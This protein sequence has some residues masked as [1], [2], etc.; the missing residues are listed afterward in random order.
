MPRRAQPA[1]AVAETTVDPAARPRPPGDTRARPHRVAGRDTDPR[2]GRRP[3]G[4]GGCR[5]GPRGARELE[6]KAATLV[7]EQTR[8]DELTQDLN[9]GRLEL[10]SAREEH[11]Q[12]AAA[13]AERDESAA[14]REREL[15]VEL[16]RPANI[17]RT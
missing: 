8:L 13:L 10:E 16:P 14:A 4:A 17:R 9:A 15:A 2:V 7:S 6:A 5:R 1:A 3:R 11:D 12:T